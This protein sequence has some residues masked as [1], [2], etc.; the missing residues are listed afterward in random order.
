MSRVQI[1]PGQMDNTTRRLRKLIQ[2]I[3]DATEDSID[4]ASDVMDL[5]ITDAV[6]NTANAA[7]SVAKAAVDAALLPVSVVTDVLD[8]ILDW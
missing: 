2:N 1:P 5:E 3:E 8:G 7:G 6:E 4:A